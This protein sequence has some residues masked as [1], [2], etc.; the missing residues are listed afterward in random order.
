MRACVSVMALPI[1]LHIARVFPVRKTAPTHTPTPPHP[2]PH[3]CCSRFPSPPPRY[4]SCSLPWWGHHCSVLL[5]L[6]T[7]AAAC[8]SACHHCL[9]QLGVPS[10]STGMAM[11]SEMATTGSPTLAAWA[12]IARAAATAQSMS[13]RVSGSFETVMASKAT[14]ATKEP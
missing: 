10:P 11:A 12:R 14:K 5:P 8:P 9:W 2:F 4:P 6:S 13:G 7:P 1:T 3:P